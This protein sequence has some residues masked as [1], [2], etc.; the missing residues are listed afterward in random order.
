MG[1]FQYIPSMVQPHFPLPTQGVSSRTV[2]S[3][4]EHLISNGE[5]FKAAFAGRD[6]K[7]GR[8]Q[9]KSWCTVW[10]SML[11]LTIT[12]PY[13]HSRVDS[14]TFTMGNP[15]PES[16]LT[17]C[18]SR[19]YPP[20]RDFEFG[21]RQWY[22]DLQGISKNWFKNQL[23]SSTRHSRLRALYSWS[24][25]SWSFLINAQPWDL[26]TSVLLLLSSTSLFLPLCKITNF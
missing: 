24:A 3:G 20:V 8:I 22:V 4:R 5:R 18:Q 12:L 19:L 1:L 17:L 15:M 25:C 6:K 23:W 13:V 11:E 9:R 21:L 14:N 2:Y 7:R 26:N 10:D 16:T